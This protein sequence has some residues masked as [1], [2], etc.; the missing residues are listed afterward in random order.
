ME[1]VA[2]AVEYSC[3]FE[4]VPI[5]G[6]V[7]CRDE[8]HLFCSTCLQTYV[9]NQVFGN[10]NLGVSRET[11]KLELEVKC[12]HGDD[13]PSGFDDAF[14]EKASLSKV[15]GKLYE[16]QGQVNIE[17]AG[18]ANV[19]RC[20]QCG[21]RAVLDTAQKVFS[22]PVHSCRFVSCRYCGEDSHCPL[23]C[24]Q[25]K[26]QIDGRLTVEEAMSEAIIRKC[27]TCSQQFVKLVGG[28]ISVSCGC[29]TEV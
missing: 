26:K 1:R 18:L 8:G 19:C 7:A 5:D 9:E 16:V 25:A 3:C 2:S 13:C 22:G 10:G 6:M 11:K 21:F 27:P 4:R 20:P 14:L 24:E 17:Q 12:F 15:L 29:G 28:C 23:P